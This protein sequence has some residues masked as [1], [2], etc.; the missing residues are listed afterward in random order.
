MYKI[1]DRRD[2]GKVILEIVAG[3]IDKGVEAAVKQGVSFAQANLRDINL[4]DLD[5]RGGNFKGADFRSSDLSHTDFR[6]ANLRN[7]E[8]HGANMH[9]MDIRGAG[10]DFASWPLW[11]GSV[12]LIID[13]EQA[14]QFLSHAFNAAKAFWP[15]GLTDEQKDWLNLF[16]RISEGGFPEFR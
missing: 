10:I 1:Y 8:F 7:A 6:D 2:K 15:G 14:K 16:H 13:E 5:L 4:N 3:T 11:C 9:G 12:G